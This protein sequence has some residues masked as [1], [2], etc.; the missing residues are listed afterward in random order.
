MGVM[1]GKRDMIELKQAPILEFILEIVRVKLNVRRN[2]SHC[3]GYRDPSRN[4]TGHSCYQDAITS[5][6]V[7][8]T[9]SDMALKNV[10]HAKKLIIINKVNAAGGRIKTYGTMAKCQLLSASEW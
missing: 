3:A 1:Q 2:A 6:S 10:D 7:V 9:D 5:L 4:R 8:V